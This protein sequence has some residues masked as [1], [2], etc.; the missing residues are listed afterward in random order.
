MFNM[1][2]ADFAAGLAQCLQ[3]GAQLIGGCGGA[4]PIHIQAI[5]GLSGKL[6]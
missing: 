2:P 1:A 3:A 4:S 5:A 6:I